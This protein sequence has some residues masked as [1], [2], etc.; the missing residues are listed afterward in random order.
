MAS[1]NLLLQS[2][3]S[4]AVIYIRL[5]DGRKL[6]LKAKTNFHIDPEK[7]NPK[8]QRPLKNLLK[9]IYYAN[10]DTDLSELKNKVLKKYNNSKGDSIDIQWLKNII[11]PSKKA[12]KKA[13]KL[14]H[15][16]DHY[17]EFKKRDVRSSTLKKCNVI[18]ELLLRYEKDREDIIFI[19]NV[20]LKFKQD[21]EE[22]CIGQD[23][24]QNTIAR[25]LRFIKTIC[26][27][28]KAN[29]AITHYQLNSIKVKYQK[30]ENI[31]LNLNEIKKIEELERDKLPKHLDN[32]RDWLLISCYCGQRVSDFMRF[33]KSMIRYEKNKKGDLKPL[34]EFTQVKTGKLMT[35]PLHTKI[36]NLLTKYDGNFPNRISDQ[37]YNDYIKKVCQLAKIDDPMRGTKFDKETK[38]K[39]KKDYPKWELVSSHI[40]RRSFATNNYGQIPTSFLM[41]MTGHSTEKMFLT[42]IGKSNKDIAMELTKYF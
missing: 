35:I 27:Y 33:E 19:K 34:L 25:A 7:W 23:Y 10:L 18:K 2:K 13:E 5:R 29:G 36:I 17:I 22:Y 41:Y 4:P 15:F 37:K 9:D 21:F 3:K 11:N 16:I 24:A 14:I 31:Y 26:Y 38:K 42:Y 32:A 39:V 30:G 12:E 8:E 6:D 20:N 28:A 40:G 1:I